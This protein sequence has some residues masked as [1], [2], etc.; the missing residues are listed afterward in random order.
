MKKLFTNKK[1]PLVIVIIVIFIGAGYYFLNQYNEKQ[2]INRQKEEEITSERIKRENVMSQVII[3][4]QE[5]LEKNN[6]S[7]KTLQSK[8]AN[9]K[10]TV[11]YKTETINN[12]KLEIDLA[13][14]IDE[15][16][17]RV[18]EVECHWYTTAGEPYYAAGGSALIADVYGRGVSAITNS[19]VINYTASDGTEYPPEWC[20]VGVYGIGARGVF[21]DD[22]PFFSSLVGLDYAYITIDKPREQSDNGYFSTL[23]KSKICKNEDVKLG[24]KLVILGYPAIG[25]KNGVTATEGIVSGVEGNYYVT[26]AKIDHGNSGGVAVLL[27]DDCYLGIP[28][29]SKTGTIE[30]MGRILN[31]DILF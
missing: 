13:T 1:L 8:V 10:P 27:K 22:R 15:W 9:I 25:T 4:Q 14:I 11:I 23:P 18:A 2:T 20:T 28:T 21:L 7:L 3:K 19:H 6:E 31:A 30:S 5:E 29:W 12:S 16:K 17:N 26:S 24:D